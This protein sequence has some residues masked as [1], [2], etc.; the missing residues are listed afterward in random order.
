MRR[1]YKVGD[2]VVRH[3]L[4]GVVDTVPDAGDASDNADSVSQEAA[5]SDDQ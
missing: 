5:E 1:G 4:V 3:A 2:L